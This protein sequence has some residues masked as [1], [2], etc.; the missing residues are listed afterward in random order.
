[1]PL[2]YKLTTAQK[3]QIDG[4][5]WNETTAFNAVKDINNVWYL[6]D[7]LSDTIAIGQTS[8]AWVLAL[9]IEYF[10][11]CVPPIV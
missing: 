3:D 5:L 7:F 8:Y 11:P 4:Q 1:M 6:P 2:G 9:P 10:E